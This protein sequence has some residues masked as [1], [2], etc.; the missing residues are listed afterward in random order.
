[1][2][3]YK[4]YIADILSLII[5]I[6]VILI[7]FPFAQL[8]GNFFGLIAYFYILFAFIG[9]NMIGIGLCYIFE[10]TR[11]YSDK[12]QRFIHFQELP[13]AK[14]QHI[15]KRELKKI[16]IEAYPYYCDICKMFTYDFLEFCEHCGA[17]NTIR[18]ASK[19]DYKNY[20]EIN[21]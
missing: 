18:K 21:L 19:G 13:S 15:K 5:G 7:I 6:G 17:K 3:E 10:K 14:K 12:Y 2:N 16:F 8:V 4:R 11:V 9:I 20:L 1:M